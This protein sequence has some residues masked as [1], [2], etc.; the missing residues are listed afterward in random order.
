MFS[1]EPPSEFV[2]P[3]RA[4]GFQP[5]A[6]PLCN[7]EPA[8]LFAAADL[9]QR[10]CIEFL[11]HF[12]RINLLAGQLLRARKRRMAKGQLEAIAA[13]LRRATA[14][15][16]ALEDRYAPIGF[17][18]EPAA[19]EGPF[20]RDV[21]FVRPA[22]PQIGPVVQSSCMAVPGLE[23]IPASELQGEPRVVRFRHGKMDL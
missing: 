21:T 17:Y 11:A 8:P 7:G 20:I 10:R 16:E 1:F 9:H 12:Y 15:L 3:R 2:D 13:R 22:L 6:W 14:R 4:R 23:F 19:V 18:G 5:G